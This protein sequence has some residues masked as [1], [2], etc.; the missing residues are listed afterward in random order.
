MDRKHLY[1]SIAIYIIFFTLLSSTGY[2]QCNRQTNHMHMHVVLL[3]KKAF[4]FVKFTSIGSILL[5]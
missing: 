5:V 1:K 3:S 2:L 4:T